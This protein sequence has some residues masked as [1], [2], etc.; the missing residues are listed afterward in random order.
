M[1][2]TKFNYPLSQHHADLVHSAS[3]VYL[4]DISL[5]AILDGRIGSNDLTISGDTLVMQAKLAEEAGYPQLA[6]NLL[7]AAEL[8]ML[9]PKVVLDAYH[10]LRPCRSTFEQL[11]ELADKFERH[12][13]AEMVANMIRQAS[14]VYRERG[15]LKN[16]S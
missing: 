16:E 8:T 5:E 2:L 3:G 13:E 12:Y 14:Q 11:E 10:A 7:R 6:A 4:E 15:L 1:T 9:P